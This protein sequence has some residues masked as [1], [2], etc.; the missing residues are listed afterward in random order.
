MKS[1]NGVCCLEMP[2]STLPCTSLWREVTFQSH[3]E[4][5]IITSQREELQNADRMDKTAVCQNSFLPN[6]DLLPGIGPWP[7]E[8]KRWTI[9]GSGAHRRAAFGLNP[10]LL[11]A[12]LWVS[13]LISDSSFSFFCLAFKN[14]F[15]YLVFILSVCMNWCVSLCVLPV[16]GLPLEAR[17]EPGSLLKICKIHRNQTK[18]MQFLF[19]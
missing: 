16:C 11:V 8:V 15:R 12:T 17:I 13:F 14:R 5:E 18:L 4:G 10:Q 7:K 6:S 19:T 1:R 9:L 2:R 3:F